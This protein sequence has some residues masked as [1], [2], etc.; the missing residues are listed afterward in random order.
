MPEP[1]SSRA[2]APSGFKRLALLLTCLGIGVAVGV[3]GSLLAGSALWYLAIPGA[4]GIGWLFVANPLECAPRH[5][6]RNRRHG[7]DP[8]AP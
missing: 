4:V 2:A 8:S 3:G 6:R 1:D 5:G 7:D